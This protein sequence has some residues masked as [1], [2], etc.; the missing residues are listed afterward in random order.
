MGWK[1]WATFSNIEQDE[2]GHETSPWKED[3]AVK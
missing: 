2:K 1:K 3:L